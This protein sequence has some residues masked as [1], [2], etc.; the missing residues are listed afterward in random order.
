MVVDA[1]GSGNLTPGDTVEWTVVLT[2]NGPP[3]TNVVFTD[4][5]PANTTYVAS[6][7][8][9]TKGTPS[10]A[11]PNLSIAIGPMAANEV[12][13]IRFRTTV[14]VNVFAGTVLSNQGSVDSDQT[15]PTPSDGDGNPGN[16]NQPTTIL[17]NGVPALAVTK[18]QSFPNDSNLDGQLNPGETIRY[19]LVVTSTGTSPAANVVFTDPIPANTS[20]LTVTSTVGTV[21]S[22]APPTVNLGP[23]VPGA[24]ATITIDVQVS[25]AAF[26]GT[27]IVN[28]G[29]VSGQGLASVP[30]N[31]VSARVAAFPT[32]QPPVGS[33]AVTFIGP[34]ILEWRMLW[35]N[36]NNAYPLAVRV[37]DAMPVGVTYIPGSLS[38]APQGT[39]ILAG[40][41][42]DGATTSVVVDATL[43]PDS[44]H[45][46]EATAANELVITFRTVLNTVPPVVNVAVAYWDGN[47]NGTVDDD[48][49]GGQIPLGAAAQYGASTIP[50][51]NRELLLLLSVLLAVCGWIQLRRR[52]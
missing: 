3:V 4:I 11:L 15:V 12:V 2:N 50:I 37:R 43:G 1:D 26:A 5:V 34:N 32:L 22:V 21:A 39:A 13:T 36:T 38:C 9:T 51:D 14:N 29:S 52:S 18:T 24:T 30:S 25:P 17:V 41:A 23:M 46:G 8:T 35:I 40:C 19:T 45:Y 16:G 33:K 20:L 48:V 31:T 10:V 44:G 42:F 6:S 7:L 49:A 28:Q 47:G 27:I